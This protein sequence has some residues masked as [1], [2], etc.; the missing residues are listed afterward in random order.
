MEKILIVEDNE[1]IATGIKD[2]LNNEGFLVDISNNIKEAM[3]L[4]TSNK[5]NLILLDI[6]LPDGNGINF[7]KTIKELSNHTAV[8]FLTAKDT[9]DDIVR[10]LELGADDYIVKPFRTRELISRIRN[11]LRRSKNISTIQ[12]GNIQFDRIN[13]VIYKENNIVE[14]TALEYKIFCILVDNLGKLV[15]REYLLGRIWDISA[16]FVNDN[17]LTVYMKRLREKIEDDPNNPKII[18]TIRGIGY[19]VDK[20]EK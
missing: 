11:V 17:T 20:N 7:Y 13:N 5:Y 12:I 4:L 15:T 10:G 1:L 18:K 16:N 3:Q 9:E 8:I 2:R 14:L 6:V 19:K